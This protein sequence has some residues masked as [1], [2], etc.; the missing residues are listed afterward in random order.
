MTAIEKYV[1]KIFAYSIGVPL[2][3][4]MISGSRAAIS[5]IGYFL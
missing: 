5:G 2:S 3:S 4:T 1:K